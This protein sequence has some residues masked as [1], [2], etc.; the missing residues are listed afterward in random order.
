MNLQDIILKQY[1]AGFA[2]VADAPVTRR[3][4]IDRMPTETTAISNNARPA[5][6]SQHPKAQRFAKVICEY[7][8]KSPGA[9]AHDLAKHLKT[10]PDRLNGYTQRMCDAG[11]LRY[12]LGPTP[13]RGGRRRYMYYIAEAV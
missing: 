2:E 10:T 4:Y 12:E 1:Q 7:L 6:L 13:D 11:V 8:R 3:H 5:V 9:T